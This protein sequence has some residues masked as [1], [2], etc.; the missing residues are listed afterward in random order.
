MK[1]HDKIVIKQGRRQ[2]KEQK[3]LGK[4]ADGAEIKWVG[5]AS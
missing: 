3:G 5:R 4:D 1:N 2:K